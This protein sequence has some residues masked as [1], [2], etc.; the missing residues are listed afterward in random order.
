MP[1]RQRR[2]DASAMKDESFPRSFDELV[3][4]AI[5]DLEFR[6]R[7]LNRDERAAALR[8]AGFDATPEMLRE[9]D[10]SVHALEDLA[11]QFANPK[12]AS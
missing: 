12:A 2:E 5:T 10:H 7:L 6:Q 11:R 3:G 4:R 1:C 9:L 8:D